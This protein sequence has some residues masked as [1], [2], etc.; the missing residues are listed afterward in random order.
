MKVKEIMKVA[1]KYALPV[2]VGLGATIG[3]IA[4]K[5]KT[6]KIDELIKKV[7]KM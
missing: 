4:D 2:L 5:K 7:E 3:A 6:E 1:E